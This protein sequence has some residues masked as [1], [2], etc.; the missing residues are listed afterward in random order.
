MILLLVV[1]KGNSQKV[2]MTENSEKEDTKKNLLQMRIHQDLADDIYFLDIQHNEGAV[3]NWLN[4]WIP[5][6]LVMLIVGLC[7]VCWAL[8]MR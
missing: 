7:F 6:V 4:L 1:I 3:T 5:C 2:Q 8:K